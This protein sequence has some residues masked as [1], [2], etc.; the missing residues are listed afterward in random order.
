M[1]LRDLARVVR[2]KNA[3]PGTL[4]LDIMLPDAASLARVLAAPWLNPRSIAA[5][6]RVPADAVCIKPFAPAHAVKIVLPRDAAGAPG[7]RDCYG[8]QAHAPLLALPV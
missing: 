8:A 6:Y 4:T 5:L 3:G 7:D 2:S 1:E